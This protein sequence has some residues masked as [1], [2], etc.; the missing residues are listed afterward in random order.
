M[1]QKHTVTVPGLGIKFATGTLAKFANGA[2]TVTVG[3]TT[4]FV[5]ATVASTMK[6]G[7]DYFAHGRLPREIRRGRPVPRR[8]LQARR[9]PVRE[10]NPHLAPVRPSVPAALPERLPQ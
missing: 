3:E 5:S 4:V 7:Q 2:V 6:P 8:L 10:G 9:P 1:N